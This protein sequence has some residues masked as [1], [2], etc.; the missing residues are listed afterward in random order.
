MTPLLQPLRVYCDCIQQEGEPVW[1]DT[2]A[3]VKHPVSP[4]Q[5]TSQGFQQDFEV[6][7]NDKRLRKKKKNE[8]IQEDGAFCI[9]SPYVSEKKTQ[10][11]CIGR[12]WVGNYIFCGTFS[13][14]L[15]MNSAKMQKFKFR[16]VVLKETPF[17]FIRL[18][19]SKKTKKHTNH[20]N[21]LI[22]HHY[23]WLLFIY[24]AFPSWTKLQQCWQHC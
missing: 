7:G 8:P 19:L 16:M 4:V 22:T 17:T 24:F 12:W 18:C 6:V 3:G 9:I 13:D 11:C 10:N 23:K 21:T 1:A 20:Y 5:M 2:R 14:I 15:E